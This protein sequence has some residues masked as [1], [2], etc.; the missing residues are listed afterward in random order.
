MPEGSAGTKPGTAGGPLRDQLRVLWGRLRGGELSPLRASGSIAVGLFI[1][2][3]PVY[4]LHLPLCLAVCLP[5]R[6]D[7]VAA[8][9][10]ANISNPFIAPFLITAEIEVGSLILTG[11]ALEFDVERARQNG[12]TGFVLQAAVGSLVVGSLLAACGGGLTWAI[13]ARRAGRGVKADAIRRTVS[14]YREAPTADRFYVASKLRSDPVVDDVIGLPGDFGA[15]VDAGCGRGQLGVLLLEL[16]RVSSLSGFDWDERKVAA[17]RAAAGSQATFDRAD[18][19]EHDFGPAD[20]VLLIDVLHYLPR[21]LQDR[22]IERAVA[23]LAAGGRIVIRELDARPGI[24]ARLT[25]LAERI[26]AK[27]RYNHAEVLEYR[28]ADDIRTKLGELGL[29]IESAA[30][31]RGFDLAN[32]LIVGR[33][34]GKELTPATP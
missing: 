30:V 22:V 28:S 5:L 29:V 31:E 10:A 9:I 11:H 33:K 16:G 14:R 20:T 23:A 25:M 34:P 6:L 21:S 4:G 24:Q 12:V 8:Y 19:A 7:V 26:G 1:G 13:M 27:V 2:S 18:F 17:A 32:V 3:L 15:T